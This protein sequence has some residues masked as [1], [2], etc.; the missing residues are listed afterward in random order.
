MRIRERINAVTL[1]YEHPRV[2][3]ELADRP[4]DLEHGRVWRIIRELS[5]NPVVENRWQVIRKLLMFVDDNPVDTLMLQPSH[6]EAVAQFPQLYSGGERARAWGNLQRIRHEDAPFVSALHLI[7]ALPPD[8]PGRFISVYLGALPAQL[9]RLQLHWERKALARR[10][11]TVK[12]Q[13]RLAGEQV[14]MVEQLAREHFP[15]TLDNPHL[16]IRGHLLGAYAAAHEPA[17]AQR[18]WQ[19]LL[20][21]QRPMMD[22]RIELG[23][24]SA[25]DLEGLKAIWDD[26]LKAQPNVDTSVMENVLT[27]HYA[28]LGGLG[29]AHEFFGYQ[30]SGRAFPQWTTFSYTEGEAPDYEGGLSLRQRFQLLM[31]SGMDWDGAAFMLSP[32]SPYFGLTHGRAAP[33]YRGRHPQPNHQEREERAASTLQ[34]V[35]YV[36]DR[37]A[38]LWPNE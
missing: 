7:N 31:R 4:T 13:R 33:R 20:E 28:R 11:T 25:R 21:H 18:H 35:H 15:D 27:M 6:A 8:Q 24:S 2:L 37:L 22:T 12:E 30:P 9:H 1:F 17:H 3:L 16:N 23:L 10:G 5:S 19:W 26:V 32:F 36:D 38:Q 34:P 29:L 14:Y